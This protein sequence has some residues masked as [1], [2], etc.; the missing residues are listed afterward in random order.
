MNELA[1]VTNTEIETLSRELASVLEAIE[2]MESKDRP[3]LTARY[4]EALG[5]LEYRLLSLQVECRA[6]QR[7]MELIQARLNR[8]ET[9]TRQGVEAIE[10]QV[11]L[12]LASWQARLAEQAS[13]L[14]ASRAF[15][16]G[17][18]FLSPAEAQRVKSA[19]RR[20]ARLL[21]PDVSSG[22]QTWFERYWPAV[23][24]AY[25][26]SDADLLEALLHLVERAVGKNASLEPGSDPAEREAERLCGLIATHAERL[27]RLKTEAPFCWADLL[28]N[29]EWLA[30]KRAA[31]EAAIESESGRWAALTSRL[32]EMTASL[33]PGDET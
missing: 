22:N 12:D 23:Q 8:G 21:H 27:A 3:Y 32:A 15:L 16:A 20:L 5:E 11:R 2:R 29:S 13:L 33:H 26:A 4:Q 19:Y 1:S 18:T 10:G 14:N 6:L 9:L 30:V 25:A 24:D 17:L 28:E 7:R 31:L